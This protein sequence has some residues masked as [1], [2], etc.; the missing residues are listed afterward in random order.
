MG[1]Y[2]Y[3]SGSEYLAIEND[4]FILVNSKDKATRFSNR[5]LQGLLRVIFYKEFDIEEEK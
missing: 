2:L 5:Y 1:K 4:S 3:K